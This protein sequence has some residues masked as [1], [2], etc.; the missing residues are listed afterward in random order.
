[1][2]T[3][4]TTTDQYGIKRTDLGNGTVVRSVEYD[5]TKTGSAL[6]EEYQRYGT[7][8]GRPVDDEDE[9]KSPSSPSAVPFTPQD[10][11]KNNISSGTGTAGGF[12]N[13]IG[14]KPVLNPMSELLQ[15]S[16]HFSFYLGSDLDSEQND[17]RAFI[18]AETGL[19]G[20]NIQ[21]VEIEGFVGPN[22]RTRNA[23]ATSITIKI[24]EPYGAQLPDLLFQAAARMNIRNYL[25]APWFLKL[26][27]HGYD[28]DGTP[29]TVGDKWIWKLV[30]IDL[31]SQISEQGSLHTIT[32]MPLAEVA[33]NNQYCMLPMGV[34]ADGE[35]VGDALKNIIKS[36]NDNIIETYGATNP[37][38]VQFEIKDEKYP[39]D[40]MA[41]VTSPFEH[42][43]VLDAP[44]DGT[45]RPNTDYGTQTSH[46]A[47][48]TDIPSVVDKLLARTETGVKIARVSREVPPTDRPDT[49]ATVRA[50]ASFMHRVDTQVEY[51]QYDAT[52]GDYAKKITYIV[53]P[54]QSV[55]L[56]TSV[57]RA[58]SF[59][60]EKELNRRKAQHAVDHGFMKKQYDYLFTGLNTEVEKFDINVNFRW[61]VAVP[62]MQSW[63]NQSGTA[64][65]VDMAVQAQNQTQQL[66][67]NKN[68]I[69]EKTSQI[70]AANKARED[71]N[72]QEDET[73]SANRQQLEAE[74]AKL[75]EE[76]RQLGT[77][78]GK[79]RD[80]VN[81]QAEQQIL[82]RRGAAPVGRITDGEDDIYQ[83]AQREEYMGAGQ[84]G[85]SF[86]P[87]SIVQDPD[88]PISSVRSG[89]NTDNNPFKSVYGAFLNQLYG[90]FD[91]NLQN[92]DLEIRGDPYWLGPGSSGPAYDSPSD[93]ETPNFMN[94]EHIFVFRFKLPQG[95]DESTGTISVAKDDKSEKKQAS[96]GN[97]NIFTGFY[98]A[99][100]VTNHFREGRFTQ[101][102]QGVRIAGWQYENIIEGR[103]LSV[104]DDTVFSNTPAPVSTGGLENS[105]RSANGTGAVNRSGSRANT[106][107][108]SG[109]LTERQLLA[110]TLMAEAGGEGKQGMQAVGEVIMN[111][112]KMKYRGDGTVSEVILADKQFSAWNGVDPRNYVERNGNSSTYQEA[113]AIAGQLLSG[114]SSN[115]T[116]GATSYL[117]VPLTAKTNGGRLPSWYRDNKDKV[118]AK[119]G[120]HTFMKGV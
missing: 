27:L 103:E 59:D 92:I 91:G 74:L 96:G 33:L 118:T 120:N 13:A 108:G 9:D 115:L 89:S 112:T 60:K 106:V 109:G 111:R 64:A 8:G 99:I 18:I 26:K 62:V 66:Q 105:T 67:Q 70:E 83:N 1:M 7:V 28:T 63:A 52:L 56:L 116:N 78:V 69:D 75:K 86:L 14:F 84:N 19:T 15:P 90:S 46:F 117:N 43:L 48:G 101:T 6:M 65:R 51:L 25:K 16:Y 5:H 44:Q 39:Y 85:T 55:K 76:N 54:Y 21:D 20:M 107:V 47:S 88:A 71:N 10:P 72:G 53:K 102:L 100:T 95:Y 24:F 98:A 31:A 57:G 35:T 34:K 104:K 23:T 4:K 68:Q 41:G 113:D 119:I 42:K 94:G 79:T 37:P 77:L 3:V 114:K 80:A 32:A 2:A 40:T 11:D 22:V 29:V 61:A 81:A 50:A 45:Q 58:M 30:L 87:I 93:D 38:F 49:E 36:M 82:Q 73:A 110:A 17:N 97:S 12:T